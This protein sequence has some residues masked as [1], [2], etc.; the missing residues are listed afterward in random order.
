VG[1][2]KC[3]I[4]ARTYKITPKTTKIDKKSEVRVEKPKKTPKFTGK[5]YKDF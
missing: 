4:K 3:K 1:I 5:F 2:E